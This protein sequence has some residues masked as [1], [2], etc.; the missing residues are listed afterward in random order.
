MFVFYVNSVVA[1]VK[2][3][4]LVLHPAYTFLSSF[5]IT[6]LAFKCLSP[7]SG[8]LNCVAMI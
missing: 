8:C 5:M 2:L 7:Q 4:C 1:I 6:L 3:V